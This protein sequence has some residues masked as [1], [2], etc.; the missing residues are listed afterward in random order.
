VRNLYLVVAVSFFLTACGGGSGGKAPLVDETAPVLTAPGAATFAAVDAAGTPSSSEDIAAF[1]NSASANDDVDGSVLVTSDA[2]D[3]FPIDS[4]LVTFS[5][6]DAAGNSA[7]ATA[8]VTIADQAAPV[9]VVP[10]DFS[11]VATSAAG[12][13]ATDATLVDFLA[14]ATASDNV[15]SDISVSNDAPD[16]FPIGETVVVFTAEDAAGNS[17]ESSALVTVTGAVQSGKGEKGPLFAATVFFDYDGDKERD[18]NEPSTLT[19]FGGNYVV[20]ETSD[21][22]SDY[23][24]VLSM[25]ENTIDALTGESYADSGVTLEAVKDSK[26]ITPMTTLYSIAVSGLEEGEGLTVEAFARAIGLPEG[27]NIN[28][29]SSFTKDESGDYVDVAT[30]SAVE[31]VAQSLMVTLEIISESIIS[32]SQTALKSDNGLTQSQA[33]AVA[34]RSLANVIVATSARN[35]EVGGVADS[36]DFSNVDDLAEVNASVLESLSSDEAGSLGALLDAAGEDAG[37]TVDKVAA[38]VSGS[39]VLSLS[40]NTIATISKAFSDLG[41]ASFGQVDASALSLVKAQAVAEIASAAEVVVAAIRVQQDANETVVLSASDVDVSAIITLDDEDSLNTTVEQNVSEVE[42]YLLTTVAPVIESVANFSA[43]ENQ[44]AVGVVVA[45]DTAGDVLTYSL[46]GADADALTISSSGVVAFISP[47]DFEVKALYSVTVTVVDSDGNSVSQEITISITDANDDAP[48]V[49]S[50]S[51]YTV[52]EG[53]SQIGAVVA[54]SPSGAALTYTLTGVDAD[55]LSISVEGLLAFLAPPDFEVKGSYSATVI[56]SDGINETS[57]AITVSIVNLNDSAPVITSLGVFAVKENSK[58]VGTVV[59]ADADFD[60]LAYALSGADAGA[61]TISRLGLLRFNSAPNF[62]VKSTYSL[63]VTVSDGLNSSVL[64]ITVNVTDVDDVAPVF[65]SESTFSA[66]ENQTA[67]GSVTATDVDSSSISFSVSI[68]DV[69]ISSDGVLSFVEPADFEVKSSYSFVV[70]ATDGVNSSTQS[71]SVSV[72]D[73]DESAPVVDSSPVFNAA[74]NQTAIG[75]VSATD[76]D[77]ES[78]SFSVSGD[79]LVIT[80]AGVLSFVAAPDYEVKKTYTATVTASDGINETAQAITVNVTDVDDVA[81]VFTSAAAFSAAENQTS[82]GTVTATDVDSASITFSVESDEIAISVG[83]ILSFIAPADFEVKSAYSVVVTATDGANSS[84]QTVS[85]TVTDAN[86]NAPIIDSSPV[87][88]A[89]E[90]QTAIGSVSATDADSASI[91]FTVSGDELVITSVGVLSFVA[92]PDY[93]VKKTYTATVT[94]SDGVNETAQAIT[95]N[96]T[97][98]DDVAPVFTSA[99]SFSALD[100]QSS[101]GVVTVTDVDSALITF[102]IS[103][104]DLAITA[105][106]VLTLASSIDADATFNAVV[107]VTDGINVATQTISVAVLLDLDGDGIANV[108]DTDDDGDGILDAN[109]EFPLIASSYAVK[110]PLYLARAYHDCNANEKFDEATEPFALTDTDGSYHIDGDCGAVTSFNTVVEMTTDTVDF[111]SGES[112]GATAVQLKTEYSASGTKVN[113]PLT[114]LLKHIEQFEGDSN[115]ADSVAIES[116]STEQLSLAFGLPDAVDLLTFNPYA[117]GVSAQMAHDVETISQKIMLVTLVVTKAIEGAGVS[118]SGTSVTDDIAHEAALDAMSKMVIETVKTQE[119]KQSKFIDHIAPIDPNLTGAAKVAAQKN[120][121][122][123]VADREHLV[124]LF[125]FLAED[126]AS[127]HLRDALEVI[128]ADVP[129]EVLE[130]ITDK[131]SEIISNI[132]I[133][134]DNHGENDFGSSDTHVTSRLKH[135][136]AEEI[137]AFAKGYRASYDANP[138]GNFS[139]VQ[140]R[141]FLTLDGPEGITSARAALLAEVE[142]HAV[143]KAL[144]TDGDGIVNFFDPDDDNDGVLDALDA[145]P[146]DASESADADGDGVGDNADTFKLSDAAVTLTDY[147]PL[148]QT[149]VTNSLSYT[150][151]GGMANIDLRAAPLNLTNIENAIYAGDFKAPVISFGLASLPT[152]SG[153]DTIAI[154]L[155]DGVDANVDA[156]ERHVKVILDVEWQSDGTTASITVPPQAIKATYKTRAGVEIDIEV[157]NVDPDVLTITKG[158][159]AYPATLEVK[160]VSLIAQLNSLPLADILSAGLYHLDVTTALPLRAP[161]GESVK[162]VSAVVQIVDAFKLAS[163]TIT[164]QDSNPGDGSIRSSSHDATLVD[165][166]LSVD[167]RSEPLSLLNISNGLN[168]LDFTSPKV[169]FGL[170]AIPSGSS[171]E[172]VTINLIDGTDASRDAGERQVSVSVDIEWEADRQDASITVPSQTLSAFYL[173]REGVKVEVE[174]NNADLDVLTVTRAG[175]GY[176]A[177]LEVKL[178]SLIAKLNDLP[179]GD[180]LKAGVFHIDVATSLP[181]VDASGMAVNGLKAIV[182]IADTFKL[183]S[184][185]VKLQDPNPQSGAV[186]TSEHD[187][188]LVDG[189]LT[190]DLRDAPLSLL[191]IEKGLYGLDFTSPKILLDLAFIPAGKGNETVVINLTDGTD[192]VRDVGERKVSVAL[193]IEWDADGNT[194]GFTV[195]AQTLSASY[196]TRDGVKIDVELDNVD[197]DVLSVSRVGAAYPASLEVKLLS[198]IAKLK[199]LPLG[200]ILGAGVFHIDV[201]TSLPM[202]NSDSAAVDGLKAIIAIVDDVAPVFTSAATF[203]AAANQTSVGTVA[204]IDVDGTPVSYSVSGSDFVVSADGVVSFVS[205]PA[206]QSGLTYSAV[207]T[208][209]SG[210]RISTQTITVTVL[211]GSDDSAEGF[212]LPKEI[213]VI[214]AK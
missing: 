110:A 154:D 196:L 87:F 15:D 40:T 104:S 168:G 103:G 52:N 123:D 141:D 61:F 135:S 78:I 60:V 208:A 181:M 84:T 7:T 133:E 175:A 79:E 167:L 106:G 63:V 145:F 100:S 43:A 70:T 128:G 75:S 71:I 184:S 191:N 107:T 214:E 158:S 14:Q 9:L 115:D 205:A 209:T 170:S 108:N 5:A 53:Q 193:N 88:N 44:T 151:L 17:V 137:F 118:A 83:G 76:A 112:Y 183:A 13:A 81:P 121:K 126:A 24:V 206:Y 1:L 194:A 213:K 82:I 95:V 54:N 21:A 179:L 93:E 189:F 119:G 3:V 86:D 178:L 30:A 202:I 80:S 166:L 134:F 186:D 77:S 48:V 116:I 207:L 55:A 152:G 23:S 201:I 125:E 211:Q 8:V 37:I 188:T 180:L 171:K 146:R 129:A 142:A 164:L 51:S 153:S 29:Y 49:T 139:D 200:D 42:A 2:P 74:E 99:S 131:T 35:T 66:A 136:A 113:T 22:P 163:S 38:Q 114:T 173:T 130:A 25:N 64:P 11:V 132:A 185:T 169:V 109:D 187:A 161:T 212:V 4:T 198:L 31:A 197:L 98:V 102:S 160:L 27:L 65:T 120:L 159:E 58:S 156:N 94:A 149:T 46:A 117:S 97:D 148:D 6:S 34:L 210:D 165:G 140:P 195:P 59:A 91:S 50:S 147:Y 176:P 111:E 62:E 155:V 41:E 57:L 162:G 174:L 90:N 45:T 39:V 56:I 138:G 73:A 172:T 127:G 92:A 47:P 203:S 192:A 101:V 89:A 32:M 68:S 72:T 33:S 20:A 199:G 67:I 182:E 144:D 96:V 16:I 124:E 36:I 69:A 157:G 204:A 105:D 26:V 18:D 177:S 85:V 150:I 143:D 122:L 12:V 190:V 19:D 10:D 28:T